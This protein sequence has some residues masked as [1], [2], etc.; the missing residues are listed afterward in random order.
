MNLPIDAACALISIGELE[1]REQGEAL[2]ALGFSL[3]RPVEFM[4]ECPACGR[5]ARF[6]AEIGLSNGLYGMCS[7]CGD[8]RVVRFTRT[9]P[10]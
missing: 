5:V 1:G 6:I 3:D 8:Q 7:Q 4:R 9:V 2:A 10:A